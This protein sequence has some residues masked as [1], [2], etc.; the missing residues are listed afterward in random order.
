MANSVIPNDIGTPDYRILVYLWDREYVD[1]VTGNKGESRFIVDIS[2]LA[3]SDIHISK[4]RNQ[5]DALEVTIEYTQFKEK[6]KKEGTMV[7]DVLMPWLTEIKIQRNFKTI[8]A[9]YLH[10]MS[11]SLGAVGREELN[12][13]CFD[14]G[15]KLDKRLCSRG[16]RNMTYPEIAQALIYEAQHELN[17]IENYA[18]EYSDNE[19]YFSEWVYNNNPDPD[20]K[21]T[22][23]DDFWWGTSTK[24]GVKLNANDK[25]LSPLQIPSRAIQQADLSYILDSNNYNGEELTFFCDYYAAEATT[26]TL[27]FCTGEWGDLTT[28]AT[29]NVPLPASP[30]GWTTLDPVYFTL[31]GAYIT[32]I[33]ISPNKQIGLSELQLYRTP[34]DGDAYD[35]DI[36][37]GIIDPTYVDD[38]GISHEYQFDDTRVRHYH[39]QNIKDA[40]FNL[41]KLE[42]DQFEFE[43]TE[44]KKFNCYKYQGNPV[45]DPAMIA[46]YP[47]IIQS[48]SVE[49]DIASITNT[50]YS[51]AD[52]TLKLQVVTED[53]GRDTKDYTRR[54]KY[55]VECIYSSS[56]FGVLADTSSYD[57]V[58]SRENIRDKCI[59]DLEAYA[60][61]RNVPSISVDSNIY[62]PDNLHLGDAIGVKVLEDQLFAYINDVYRVYSLDINITKDTVE[63]MSFTLVTPTLATLQIISFPRML[64]VMAS[65]LKRLEER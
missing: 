51:H 39:Q 55:A 53:G 26:L 50:N 18:F 29:V 56:R 22:R 46:T 27:T 28:L 47:G 49:R 60:D 17:W 4:E 25:I 2:A 7:K 3:T 11:L 13:R 65:T 10:S 1:P 30:D 9:G 20:N 59:A 36:L 44:D 14:W 57:G 33:Q 54:W 61:I 23:A 64:K 52:E 58:G 5:P 15:N 42:A 43:F 45:T 21:P 40:I 16:F 8:F 31:P 34:Q 37:Q 24:V 62:N 38:E 6:L 41:T 12:L 48:L 63:S 32:Y 35:L 19:T